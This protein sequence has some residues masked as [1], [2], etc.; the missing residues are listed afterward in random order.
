LTTVDWAPDATRRSAAFFWRKGEAP[1]GSSSSLIAFHKVV[2]SFGDDRL[3]LPFTNDDKSD[4][5][6][7]ENLAEITVLKYKSEKRGAQKKRDFVELAFT[8]A[9]EIC[10]P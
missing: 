9:G 3:H 8:P 2:R 6:S 4:T 5:D 1:F 7:G 10:G